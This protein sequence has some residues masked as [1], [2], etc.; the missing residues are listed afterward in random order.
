MTYDPKAKQQPAP[1]RRSAD[2]AEPFCGL[3]F[4]VVADKHGYF[5]FVRVYSGHLKASTRVY[6]PNQDKK[7]NIMNRS[8]K[9]G[10]KK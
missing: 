6:N 4:K 5:Y 9:H 10:S 8:N 2:A 7:E 1:V 3:V